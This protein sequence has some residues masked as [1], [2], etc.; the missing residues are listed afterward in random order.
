MSRSSTP[1]RSDR[2]QTEPLASL[3]AIAVL[4]MALG[5]YGMYLTDTLPGTSERSV[6]GPT[7]DRVWHALGSD[8]TFDADRHDADGD[9]SVGDGAID[10]D[11]AIEPRDLPQGR[12]VY[13]A[14]TL[15]ADDGEKVLVARE[16][17]GSD[18]QPVASVDRPDDVD[19]KSRPIPIRLDSGTVT[20]GQLVVEVWG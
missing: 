20:G 12:S 8:G 10:L 2:G 11:G 18:G 13:V 16:Q 17:Y 4:A 19:R 1:E 3:A 5:A 7:L 15:V 9:W 14:V 6:E